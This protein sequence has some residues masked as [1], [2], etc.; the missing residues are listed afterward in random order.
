MEYEAPV[1]DALC[2]YR[3]VRVLHGEVFK[4]CLEAKSEIAGLPVE[5]QVD[6]GYVIHKTERLL[7]EIQ[8]HVNT[9][10]GRLAKLMFLSF[11]QE[12][13]GSVRGAFATGRP[14]AK[15]VP[16]IPRFERDPDAYL[17]FVEALGVDPES[18]AAQKGLVVPKYKAIQEH[19]AHCAEAGEPCAL[20]TVEDAQDVAML[21]HPVKLFDIEEESQK[22]LSSSV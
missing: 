12:G 18:D 14:D 13:T 5:D 19:I 9:T 2:T 20:P 15:D 16:V 6:L 10:K 3:K 22:A 4:T 17:E 1:N 11:V 8:T 21:Y 7:K